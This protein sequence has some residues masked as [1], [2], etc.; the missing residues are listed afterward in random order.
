[1]ALKKTMQLQM[2]TANIHLKY[3]AALRDGGASLSILFAV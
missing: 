2:E 1:M 3:L